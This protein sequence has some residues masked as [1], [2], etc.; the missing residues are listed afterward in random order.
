MKAII[1][2][3]VQKLFGITLLAFVPSCAMTGRNQSQTLDFGRFE[4]CEQGRIAGLS[5]NRLLEES[6]K[7]SLSILTLKNAATEC[8]GMTF[9]PGAPDSDATKCILRHGGTGFLLSKDGFWQRIIMWRAT[10]E[11]SIPKAATRARGFCA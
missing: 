8:P 2:N 7:N 5:G 11:T 10:A 4:L 3:R 9:D 6:Y 1:Q